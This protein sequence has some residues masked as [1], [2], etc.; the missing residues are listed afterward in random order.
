MSWQ[1]SRGC[2]D[3]SA[4]ES[5]AWQDVE[6]WNRPGVKK[7]KKTL[8][9]L[10]QEVQFDLPAAPALISALLMCGGWFWPLLLRERLS[11]PGK[12]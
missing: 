1:E 6:R 3:R 5:P 11:K 12:V 8:P 7:V 4:S 10:R 9:G 2:H